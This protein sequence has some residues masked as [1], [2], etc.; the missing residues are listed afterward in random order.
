MQSFK[1]IPYFNVFLL[2]TILI[3]GIIYGMKTNKKYTL[4]LDESLVKNA[5]RTT[6]KSFTETVRQ[7]LKIIAATK[8][9]KELASMKGTVD[10]DLD[11][12]S[13]RSKR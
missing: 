7:G 12:A 9:Y 2:N 8:T 6:G 3:Y 13:L 5:V 10:L 1:W 4:E 11:V